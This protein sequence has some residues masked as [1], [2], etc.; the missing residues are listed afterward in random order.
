MKDITEISNLYMSKLL[1][2]KKSFGPNPSQADNPIEYAPDSLN[3]L[4]DDTI[5]EIVDDICLNFNHVK[6]LAEGI[7]SHELF[8][9]DL[10]SNLARDNVKDEVAADKKEIP[11]EVGTEK[12]GR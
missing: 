11:V 6:Q 5:W 12:D 9:D 10:F 4:S 7:P 2:L 1:S 8:S 3:N